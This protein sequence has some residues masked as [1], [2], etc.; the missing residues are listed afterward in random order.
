MQTADKLIAR[1][2]GLPAGV[3]YFYHHNLFP[4]LIFGKAGQIGLQ[5]RKGD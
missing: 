1:S 4:R 2:P 5:V 3:L